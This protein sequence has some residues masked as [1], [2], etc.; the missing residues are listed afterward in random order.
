MR[1]YIRKTEKIEQHHMQLI[2]ASYRYR[3]IQL[4]KEFIKQGFM[5][6][7]QYDQLIE[8]YKVY[9]GLGGNGPA[10]QYYDKAIALPVKEKNDDDE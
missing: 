2:I 6:P 8:F 7:K 10:K 4:C 3:L 1:E 9:F 5:T